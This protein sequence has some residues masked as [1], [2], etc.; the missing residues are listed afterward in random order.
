M[1]NAPIYLGGGGG[2]GSMLSQENL[3]IS[4]L[5]MQ[6]YCLLRALQA[7]QAYKQHLFREA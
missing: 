5:R 6:F 4:A 2:I 3:K 7:T 1:I